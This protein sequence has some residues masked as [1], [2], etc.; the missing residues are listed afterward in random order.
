M[1]DPLPVGLI[2]LAVD[3]GTGNNWQCQVA[4]NAINV[5][6]CV[7]DLEPN[8][9]NGPDK[10][11]TIKVTVFMTAE[12]G[13]SLDNEA[14]IDTLLKIEEFD[15]PGEG[16]NCSTHSSLLMFWLW[17]VYVSLTVMRPSIS[18]TFA[19]IARCAPRTLGAWPR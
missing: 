19:S 14:C 13:R 1:H 18:P 15:P 17:C 16:D 3:T 9:A 11:V 10:K 8:V 12:G 2:P 5:L 6:D 7:G 4:E